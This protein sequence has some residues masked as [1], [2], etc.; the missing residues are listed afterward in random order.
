[1]ASR[2]ER[3][4]AIEDARHL[5]ESGV[6]PSR[7]YTVRTTETKAVFG[8]TVASPSRTTERPANP[9]DGAP[10]GRQHR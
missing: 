3:W 2:E 10:D 1:M 6:I 7:A 5:V 8:T 4:A 9:P